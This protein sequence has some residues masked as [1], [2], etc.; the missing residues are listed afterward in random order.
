MWLAGTM[1]TIPKK[2]RY[3]MQVQEK[4]RHIDVTIKGTGLEELK[5]VLRRTLPEVIIIDDTNE[6]VKWE[7]TPLAKK[8]RMHKTPGKLLQAYRERMGFSITE[9][10]E[11]TGIKYTN[12]SAMEHDSRAIGLSTARKLAAAL[13]CDYTKFLDGLC[14]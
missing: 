7:D 9:L 1:R 5:N 11:K 2:S 14:P 3:I 8:I 4:E 13:G 10:A 6:A 12:I